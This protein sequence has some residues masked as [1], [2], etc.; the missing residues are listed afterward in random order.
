[1]GRGIGGPELPQGS[2]ERASLD[3]ETLG[4]PE[5]E[6]IRD[7]IMPYHVEHLHG[8]EEIEYG[9]DEL[10][11]VSVFRNARPYIREFIEH[12]LSLGVRHIVLM[13]NDSD[14][15]SASIARE[16]ENVTVLRTE[17]PW[18]TYKLATR[19][20]LIKRFG[21]DRWSM[22]VD[23][24]ELFDYPYSDVISLSAL[25]GYL[26]EKSYT[27]VVAH[28]L[29]I[30]P[31]KLPPSASEAEDTSIKESHRF[32]DLSNIRS[33]RYRSK[34]AADNV[35]SNEEIKVLSGGVEETFFGQDLVLIKHPLM[36][37]DNEI[38]PIGFSSH[39][40][41][42]VRVADFTCVL[43]H[44]K[45]VAMRERAKQAI[46]RRE[47][48][49]KDALK[50]RKYLDALEKTPDLQLKQETSKE[51][52]RVNDL[53]DD[54]FLVVS[55]DY[56]VFVDEEEDNSDDP[57]IIRSRPRRLAGAFSKARTRER[58]QILKARSLRHQ[59]NQ[60]HSEPT[61]EPC[62]TEKLRWRVRDL[63]RRTK[64]AGS[65]GGSRLPRI[66]DSLADRLRR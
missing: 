23:I 51:L 16:Y 4:D 22:Y 12:Y 57:E 56:M 7:E 36:F 21:K 18:G 60:L 47:H 61:A 3:V 55:E 42:N 41:N 19:R 54:G 6:R 14:D 29:D 63:I 8:P 26:R 64:R 38:E 66:L 25:L 15:D 46:R 62:G 45:F 20:Y 49:N 35:V 2:L 34:W 17:A 33:R 9:L 59:L 28:M 1:M 43:F 30:F 53:V 52:E 5:Q 65:S 39:W 40:V 48:Y 44:Y 32:Y 13:D 11:V 24:D 27:A 37:I 31:A 10:V 58:E 50:Y